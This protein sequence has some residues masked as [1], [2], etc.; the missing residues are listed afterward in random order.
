M[1]FVIST[2]DK[3]FPAKVG[4]QFKRKFSGSPI[5]LGKTNYGRS[6]EIS[7]KSQYWSDFNG[8]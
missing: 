4:I 2:K 3:T 5:S 7:I 6:E 1:K 8:S